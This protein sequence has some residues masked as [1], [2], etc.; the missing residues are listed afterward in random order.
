MDAAVS[1]CL[2]RKLVSFA[3]FLNCVMGEQ[4]PKLQSSSY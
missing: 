3:S 4:N 2:V 1:P